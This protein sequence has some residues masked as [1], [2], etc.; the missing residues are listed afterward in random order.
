[1]GS[2]MCI[3]DRKRAEERL[4]AKKADLDVERAKAALKRALVR[5]ATK[6]AKF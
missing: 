2:E 5:L 1:M 3:R 6:E 4:A